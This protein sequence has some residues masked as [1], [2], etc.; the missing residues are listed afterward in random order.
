ME[1]VLFK[2]LFSSL[3]KGV[4]GV[5]GE[6]M[7]EIYG[8]LIDASFK[9]K[10]SNQPITSITS[11]DHYGYDGGVFGDNEAV[12]EGK[13][14]LTAGG[15][16]QL[17]KMSSNYNH[18]AWSKFA[19]VTITSDSYLAPDG[20]VTADT[21]SIS[22]VINRNLLSNFVS[23][24]GTASFTISIWVYPIV[25]TT[26]LLRLGFLTSLDISD[27]KNVTAGSWQL[28]TLSGSGT[29]K[30]R[31][32]LFDNIFVFIKLLRFPIA[33]SFYSI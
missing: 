27:T 15:Y 25:D 9:D 7:S 29:G 12:I 14:L 10:V 33:F 31:L 26:I 8:F 22:N 3:F 30:A 23:F 19:S 6:S 1:T 32:D 28:I 4:F 20:T 21:Y 5:G 17:I 16:T 11:G 24:S 2:K 13:G 18:D